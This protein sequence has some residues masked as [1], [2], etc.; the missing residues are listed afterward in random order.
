MEQPSYYGFLKLLM[1]KLN[2]VKNDKKISFDSVYSK[3]FIEYKED[4]DPQTHRQYSKEVAKARVLKDKDYKKA[5]KEYYKAINDFED[6]E[7]CVESFD[8][9]SRMIQSVSANVR[10]EHK[11]S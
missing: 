6:I 3:L 1:N 11:N 4:I 10:E 8:Q 5:A 7:T 9:R 2:R